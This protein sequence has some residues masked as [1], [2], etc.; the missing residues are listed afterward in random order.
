L[1]IDDRRISGIET[2]VLRG[3]GPATNMKRAGI[4]DPVLTEIFLP[5]PGSRTPTAP[6][7]IWGRL[8]PGRLP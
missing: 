5:S 8:Q 6:N 3:A 4:P 1:K 7:T 2:L